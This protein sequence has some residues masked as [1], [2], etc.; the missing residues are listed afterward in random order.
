MPRGVGLTPDA[1]F[2][3]AAGQDTGLFQVISVG[4]DGT[5]FP[6]DR[7]VCSMRVL[8]FC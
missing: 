7:S 2:I 6:A 8:F 3:I 5:L 4:R 1:E